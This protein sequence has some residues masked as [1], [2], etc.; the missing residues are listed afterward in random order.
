MVNWWRRRRRFLLFV[1]LLV[2][3]IVA[4]SDINII[5]DAVI[6]NNKVSFIILLL[7][8]C[9]WCYYYYD[10]LYHYNRYCCNTLRLIYRD[11]S[12]LWETTRA[13]MRR[14]QPY[15]PFDQS[16]T[17]SYV[18][19]TGVGFTFK[20]QCFRFN[21]FPPKPLNGLCLIMLFVVFLQ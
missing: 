20:F 11:M 15:V 4:V 13:R 7:F 12:R 16:L 9:C 2:L 1:V 3:V 8:W 14:E 18:A 21:L 17:V 10:N 5:N 6:Y 19:L